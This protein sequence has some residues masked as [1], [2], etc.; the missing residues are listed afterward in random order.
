VACAPK[1]NASYLAIDK[2]LSLVRKKKEALI[3]PYLQDSHYSGS[4]ELGHGIG[5]RYAHAYENHYV[6]QQ[7]L[8]DIYKEEKFYEPDGMGYEK[9]ILDRFRKINNVNFYKNKEMKY[10]E[11][12]REQI[13][14][15]RQND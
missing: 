6:D 4:K 7:Y 13:S 10:T 8:P 12:G 3:P 5:Y 11:T 15:G 9:E 14:G 2:A 1:S